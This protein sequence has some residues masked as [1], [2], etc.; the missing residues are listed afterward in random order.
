MSR[1]GCERNAATLPRVPR[2]VARTRVVRVVVRFRAGPTW[3]SGAPDD[4]PGWD[5]HAA[6]V[7]ELVA[8]GTMVMGGPFSDHSGSLIVLENLVEDE[9][10]ELVARDPFVVNGVFVLEDVRAWNVYVDELTP[11]I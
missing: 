1:S 11:G 5:D 10:R 6:F 3:T 2:A 4:Q 8:R 7:D 9:A